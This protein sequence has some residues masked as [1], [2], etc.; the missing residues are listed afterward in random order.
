[1]VAAIE[2]EATKQMQQQRKTAV[3]AERLHL[4]RSP[5]WLRSHQRFAAMHHTP[6]HQ[7][8]EAADGCVVDTSRIF[9]ALSLLK[10]RKGPELTSR[11]V[12]T[13]AVGARVYVVESRRA[14]DGGQR[15]L[16]ADASKSTEDTRS[17]PTGRCLRATPLG[18]VTARRA[19]VGDLLLS[20]LKTDATEEVVI[21][22]SHRSSTYDDGGSVSTSR[23]WPPTLSDMQAT[24]R[25]IAASPPTEPIWPLVFFSSSAALGSSTSAC[26]V[27]GDCT[28][29]PSRVWLRAVTCTGTCP[30]ISMRCSCQR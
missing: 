6:M 28:Q 21:P 10:V 25:A 30:C 17:S 16:V 24:G 12:S 29:S 22:F 19:R 20:L 8:S 23:C 9:E 1:M 15:A 11:L 2:L 4:R 18:W 13:L 3:I 14:G 5:P 27:D 7:T 26:P